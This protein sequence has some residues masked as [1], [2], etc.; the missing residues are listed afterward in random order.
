MSDVK[1][2]EWDLVQG[3][4]SVSLLTLADGPRVDKGV[5]LRVIEK[6]AYDAVVRERIAGND[7]VYGAG[8]LSDI[9]REALAKEREVRYRCSEEQK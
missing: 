1:L 6:S 8:S 2:R 9:A 5:R 3:D 7:G 4:G